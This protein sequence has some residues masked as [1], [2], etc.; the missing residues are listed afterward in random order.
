MSDIKNRVIDVVAKTLQ[1]EKEK[2]SETSSFVEDL[3]A[4][5]I[6]VVELVMAFETEFG[7]EISD[8]EAENI[9]TVK[10]AITYLEKN[11]TK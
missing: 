2:V 9:R 6:F 7:C 10:D 5:S 11:A 8:E 4:D 1:V 3:N